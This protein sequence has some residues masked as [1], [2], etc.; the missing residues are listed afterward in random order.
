MNKNK[1]L[2]IIS[3]I[4]IL[5]IVGGIF[6]FFAYKE[7]KTQKMIDKGIEYINKKLNSLDYN[8]TIEVLT[9]Y[10]DS[11]IAEPYYLQET[12]KIYENEIRKNKIAISHQWN[13][14]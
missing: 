8:Q 10:Y 13:N 7:Y 5:I 1:K 14:Q 2:I 9:K 4:L 12:Y 6:S 11:E 3:V